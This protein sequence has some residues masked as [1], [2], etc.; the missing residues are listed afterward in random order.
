MSHTRK[1][2]REHDVSYQDKITSPNQVF[3]N[4][5][6]FLMR[7]IAISKTKESPTNHIYVHLL[8][9]SVPDFLKEN[10]RNKN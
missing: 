5:Q 10:E 4:C 9:G 2:Q 3:G 6:Q 1:G 8:Q 7:S